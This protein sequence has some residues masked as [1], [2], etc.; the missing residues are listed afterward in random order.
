MECRASADRD[1]KLVILIVMKKSLVLIVVIVCA[2]APGGYAGQGNKDAKT[3]A[4]LLEAYDSNKD[5]K[6]DKSERHKMSKKDKKR[7]R[8]AGVDKK[9]SKKNS[10]SK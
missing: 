1:Q 4:A 7:A 10:Q 9:H 5:G 8:K 6:I 3:K 2:I